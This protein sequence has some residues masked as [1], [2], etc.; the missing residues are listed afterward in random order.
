[1]KKLILGL[2][3]L[4]VGVIL[5]Y[6]YGS[7]NIFSYVF[8]LLG[9][10]YILLG[11]RELQNSDIIVNSMQNRPLAEEGFYKKWIQVKV[12][13]EK[14]VLKDYG[15]SFEREAETG[16]VAAMNVLSGD[17]MSNVEIIKANQLLLEY[18]YKKTESS[19]ETIF[20]IPLYDVDKG[21]FSMRFIAGDVFLYI[22]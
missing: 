14:C 9:L 1:M 21:N 17:E 2:S 15:Y 10:Y 12:E 19:E 3:S 13:Y 22:D 5:F 20:Q 6:C 7:N 18:P 8:L 11:V 4:L 16:R